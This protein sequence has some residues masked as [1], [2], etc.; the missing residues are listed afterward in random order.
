[1]VFYSQNY[2]YKIKIQASGRI[3]RRNTPFED[4]Y[5]YTFISPASIDIAI[6]KALDDKKNFNENKF[7]E[8]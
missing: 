4:L 5:Y 6:K 3:D 8:D 1:M 7:I 2:S